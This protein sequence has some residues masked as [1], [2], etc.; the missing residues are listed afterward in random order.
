MSKRPNSSKCFFAAERNGFLT[1]EVCIVAQ[2]NDDDLW[3]VTVCQR[4]LWQDGHDQPRRSFGEAFDWCHYGPLSCMLSEAKQ[5]ALAAG[6]HR[7]CVESCI[8]QIFA[9]RREPSGAQLAQ[10]EAK[11]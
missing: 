6:Y 2:Q 9:Q 10:K 3:R 11:Q 5:K 1:V 7:A 4:R 8:A